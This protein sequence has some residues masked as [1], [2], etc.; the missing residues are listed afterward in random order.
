MINLAITET[1]P[2]ASLTSH[3]IESVSRAAP[4][5]ILADKNSDASAINGADQLKRNAKCT[6]GDRY[7]A[8]IADSPCSHFNVSLI[9]AITIGIIGIWAGD[10]ELAVDNAGWTSRGTLISNRETQVKLVHRNR[11]DLWA[12]ASRGDGKDVWDDLTQ[13]VQPC[14]ENDDDDVASAD[15]DTL[16]PSSVPRQDE[17]AQHEGYTRSLRNEYATGRIAGT[18]DARRFA[19][20]SH[21]GNRRLSRRLNYPLLERQSN[22]IATNE[23]SLRHPLI[24]MARSVDTRRGLQ[25]DVTN[26]TVST[27]YREMSNATSDSNHLLSGCDINWYF[28][29]SLY[30]ETVADSGTAS[31][32]TSLGQSQVNR[33]FGNS[34]LNGDNIR[35]ICEAEEKTQQVLVANEACIVCGGAPSKRCLPPY[36]VVLFARSWIA[37][38]FK[39]DCATLASTWESEYYTVDLHNQFVQCSK[40]L[41]QLQEYQSIEDGGVPDS[42]PNDLF[43]PIL[44]DDFFGQETLS[45][46]DEESPVENRLQYTSSIFATRPDANVVDLLYRIESQFSRGKEESAG[47]LVGVYDTQNESFNELLVDEALGT[48]MILALRSAVVTFL[49]M[50]LHTR[51]LFLSIVGL[52]QMILSFPLAYFVY[53]F[54]VQF[55]FFPFLN[56]VGIFVVLTL[57]VVDILVVVDK[58]KNARLRAGFDAPTGQVAAVVFPDAA[59]CMLLTSFT[60]AFAF[61]TTATCPVVSN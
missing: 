20:A 16:P 21:G 6:L 1:S 61:F 10:L 53:T 24:P 13:H 5:E 57:E 55:A 39:M 58:W 3:D 17:N 7:F 37:G 27:V 28:S 29:P 46:S 31:G 18:D 9:A 49:A 51:S 8:S 4:E 41:K 42:C 15:D 47:S 32:N 33:R 25:E 59:I 19:A 30:Q 14:W 2:Q 56:F 45:A 12:S 36:S 43:T 34:L 48:D 26:A 23:Q 35:A 44:L 60:T 52:T 22:A 11:R 54:V 40:D 38:G 50:L